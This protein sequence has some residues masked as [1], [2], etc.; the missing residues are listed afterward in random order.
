MQRSLTVRSIDGI[1]FV[2]GALDADTAD[3]LSAVM[4]SP[5]EPGGSIRM[6]LR[7]VS[8]IDTGGLAALV[9]LKA[10]AGEAPGALVIRDPHPRV[11]HLLAVTGLG[12]LFTIE[13]DRGNS[14]AAM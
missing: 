11:R 13:D 4:E 7:G 9:L 2:S 14:A 3:E 8:F 6:D 12:D 10:H 1:F 5:P